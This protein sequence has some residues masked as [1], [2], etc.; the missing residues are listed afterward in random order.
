MGRRAMT[1]SEI[2]ALAVDF[3]FILSVDGE[4]LVWQSR[5]E[6][7][8]AVLELLQEHKPAIIKL[9]QDRLRGLDYPNLRD[10]DLTAKIHCLTRL[11]DTKPGGPVT[12]WKSYQAHF[13]RVLS[14]RRETRTEDVA[15]AKGEADV[16][17]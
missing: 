8:E 14:A 3:G 12:M 7:S 11:I 2:I 4:K 16:R 9:L 5:C 15:D 10:S 6:P 1:P 13:E 17:N